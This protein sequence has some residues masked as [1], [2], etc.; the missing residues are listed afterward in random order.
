M[1]VYGSICSAYLIAV[2]W[3]DTNYC[4]RYPDFPQGVPVLQSADQHRMV[5]AAW[6]ACQHRTLMLSPQGALEL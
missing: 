1:V 5:Q 4:R 3:K 6:S 2:L